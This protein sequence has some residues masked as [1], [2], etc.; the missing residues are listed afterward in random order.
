MGYTIQPIKKETTA[1]VTTGIYLTIFF[2]VD[3]ADQLE[4]RR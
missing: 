1:N 3:R 4:C 2:N